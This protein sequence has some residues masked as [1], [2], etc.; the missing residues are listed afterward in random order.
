MK[1]MILAAGFGERLLPYTRHTPKPLF[2]IEG[3]PL[4][5]IIINKLKQAGCEAIIVNTHHLS[6]LI[7]SFITEQNY[8]VPVHIRYE[9]RI[10]GTGGGIKNTA[11]FWDR[12]PFFVINSDI[13][14]DID[15]TDLYRFHLGH[16]DPATL[17]LCDNPQF[18]SVTVDKSG[19]ITCFADQNTP[20]IS[21]S[22]NTLTFTGIQVIDPKILDF[23]PEGSFSTIIDAYRKAKS[24]G[25]KIRAFISEPSQ[26][27]DMG[28]PERYRKAVFDLM[29]PKAF[30]NA[31]PEY[32]GSRISRSELKGDGSDRIWYRL[33]SNGYTLILSDHGIRKG[34][35]R[36][37]IDA[38][39][40]IGRHLFD[41][42]LPVPEIHLFDTFSGLVFTNDLGDISLQ[43]MVCDS[44]DPQQIANLYEPV[45]DQMI[46][47][48]VFG[49]HGFDASWTYQS[50]RYDKQLILEKECKY[51]VDAF[52]NGF[53]DI[54][55][56]VKDLFAE[57]EILAE[58]ALCH[59]VD[60]F[61]HRDMQSRNIMVHND[62]F[63]FIDF[64]GG[65]IGPIQYDLASLLIDPYVDL[66]IEMQ[67]RLLAYAI[68]KLSSY[69][70]FDATGFVACFNHCAIARNLQ[71]LGAF[72]FL[73]RV[74]KKR[75]FENYI[76]AAVKSLARRLKNDKHSRFPILRSI[77]ENVE[78]KKL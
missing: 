62:Q 71:I 41:K 66:S 47:L 53:L 7:E 48:S 32:A 65:R 72:G 69:I 29:A 4:L 31:Y 42:G 18:N 24:S 34:K 38:F 37:E 43:S 22:S 2:T 15:L 1:A 51:F 44:G 67:N 75:Y 46:K 64:Q 78:H 17:V 50:A 28:T 10:L 27:N 19:F 45:I 49:L 60:G 9:P 16:P 57:F 73:S 5:D 70:R 25:Y 40:D 11:D 39:V 61:M 35:E 12:A 68:R 6:E 54:S 36:S 55:A 3:R 59:S 58:K 20:N 77:I 13:V 23:I 8:S 52:L 74:K 14:F 63:Y 76:P 26:W 30:R 21:H 56:P 33:H